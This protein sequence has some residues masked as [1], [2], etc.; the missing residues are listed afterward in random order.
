MG[1]VLPRGLDPAQGGEAP[2]GEAATLQAT[3]HRAKTGS[4]VAASMG[5]PQ[6]G[7]AASVGRVHCSRQRL[8]GRACPWVC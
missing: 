7:T 3:Q 1:V 5:L 6:K 2:G 4:P 8:A